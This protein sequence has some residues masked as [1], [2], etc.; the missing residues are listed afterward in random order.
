[1]V[2]F[3]RQLRAFAPLIA[4][5]MIVAALLP[6]VSNAHSGHGPAHG[7]DCQQLAASSADGAISYTEADTTHCDLDHHSQNKT[8]MHDRDATAQGCCPSVAACTAAN[9]LSIAS[10]TSH[11]NVPLISART[12]NLAYDT[13]AFSRDD[14][15]ELQPPR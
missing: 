9:C 15:V 4:F 5:A 3:R 1:M 14:L 10:A 2:Y 11:W 12:T 13:T 6:V 8:G 7:P